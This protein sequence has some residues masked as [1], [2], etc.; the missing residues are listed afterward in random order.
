MVI[1]VHRSSYKAS[2]TLVNIV[3]KLEFSG[4]IFEKLTNIKFSGNP[5]SVAKWFHAD[6][7]TDRHR[8][9]N[10]CLS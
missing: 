4:K 5:F 10:S 6:G 3:M 8:E 1:N 7:R 2:F 9:A